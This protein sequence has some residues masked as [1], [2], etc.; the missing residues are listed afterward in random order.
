MAT[1]LDLFT[2]AMDNSN[3]QDRVRV[4]ISVSVNKVVLSADTTSPPFSQ[5]QGA[6]EKRVAWAQTALPVSDRTM[7]AVLQLVLASNRDKTVEQI[8][9]ATDDQLQGQVDAVVDVLAGVAG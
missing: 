1:Y 9:L 7:R 5:A 6:R 2:E 4:A 8:G 3:L